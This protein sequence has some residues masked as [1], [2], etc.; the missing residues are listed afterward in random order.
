MKRMERRVQSN[1][2]SGNEKG[3]KRKFKGE[4]EQFPPVKVSKMDGKRVGTEIAKSSATR[5]TQPKYE[6]SRESIEE[7][8]E[9]Y[10]VFKKWVEENLP[11]HHRKSYGVNWISIF[12]GKDN[13]SNETKR[14]NSVQSAFKGTNIV[15]TK[16]L[17]TLAEKYSLTKGKWM[18]FKETGNNIDRLW[19]TIADG[20]IKGTIPA[21]SAIVSATDDDHVICI[22][23]NNFLNKAD[24][25]AIRDGIRNS[26]IQNS[27]KYKPNIYKHLGIDDQNKWGIDP[28]LYRDES[29]FDLSY[30][31]EASRSAVAG[32]TLTRKYSPILSL[33]EPSEKSHYPI[34]LGIKAIS[35]VIRYGNDHD[36]IKIS[37]VFH[38]GNTIM[39]GV[40]FGDAA[41]KFKNRLKV[42]HTYT[43][44]NHKIEES[45]KYHDNTKY[46]IQLRENT[47]IKRIQPGY[48]EVPKVKG[49]K[50]LEI[51]QSYKN[52]LVSTLKVRIDK[53]GELSKPAKYFLRK[54][55]ISDETGKIRVS[56]WSYK[57]VEFPH[58]VGDHIILRY[59]TVKLE[60]QHCFLHKS[61]NSRI[62]R[63][64]EQ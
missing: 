19:R 11:S 20:V 48:A 27:L 31:E 50:I 63:C 55:F 1:K 7:C 29:L 34:M 14:I 64:Q 43:F 39:R 17:K 2:C 49:M 45:D 56:M 23:N 21:V 5:V 28:I 61:D 46:T 12:R 59:M 16:T 22:Q 41:R 33:S 18:F 9:E 42:G 35:A 53:I 58:G 4:G 15:T 47:T 36:E 26:G 6:I 32:I 37:I 13:Y 62:V 51:N 30:D 3:T 38:D 25:F 57:K 8:L 52:L 40:A 10:P 54:V 60:N 24:V 44:R